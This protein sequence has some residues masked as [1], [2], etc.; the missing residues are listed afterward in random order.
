M[1]DPHPSESSVRLPTARQQQAGDSADADQFE[2]AELVESDTGVEAATGVECDTDVESNTGM[3][4]AEATRPADTALHWSLFWSAVCVIVLAAI[5]Q[6]RGPETVVI[7]V[8]NMALPGSCTYKQF[9]GMECPGCGLTRCFISLAHGRPVA[10][11]YFNPAGILFFAIVVAQI[12]FRG[13]QIWRIRRGLA[14]LR[15]GR[16]S[17][18][19]LGILI[20]A[21][22][23]QWLARNFFV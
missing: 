17:H 4:A 11:W 8:V 6:V 13:I 2:V 16:F 18:F 12:P 9:V 15:L 23:A 3:E 21:L 19:L 14:E 22:V 7:P 1:T 20:F 5:L 10:A